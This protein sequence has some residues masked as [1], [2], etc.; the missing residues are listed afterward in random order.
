MKAYYTELLFIW[1]TVRIFEFRKVIIMATGV[2]GGWHR[3]ISLVHSSVLCLK[4]F[5]IAKVPP[6]PIFNSRT[7][8]LQPSGF[9]NIFATRANLEKAQ[10]LFL[11]GPISDVVAFSA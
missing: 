2:I 5:G 6:C 10:D 8:N 7:A 1:V 9:S 4:K 3:Y 11:K